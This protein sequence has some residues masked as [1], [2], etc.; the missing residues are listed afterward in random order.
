[1]YN[2]T[3]TIEPARWNP[4]DGIHKITSAFTQWNMRYGMRHNGHGSY[5][6]YNSYNGYDSWDS[7]DDYDGYNGY[8]GYH[9]M[10]IC[11]M[12]PDQCA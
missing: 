4:H 7:Y 9:L 1:M 6:G 5:D 11:L 10:K 2:G 8:D 3:C 12:E